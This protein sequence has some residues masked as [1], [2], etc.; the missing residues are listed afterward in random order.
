[1]NKLGVKSVSTTVT[2]MELSSGVRL[3]SK[4]SRLRVPPWQM[5]SSLLDGVPLRVASWWTRPQIDT[6]TEATE[7]DCWDPSLTHPAGAV[8]IATSGEFTGIKFGLTGGSGINFNHAKVGVSTA[9]DSHL[10]IF[11]DMNQQGKLSGPVCASSQN[12]RG[13]LFYVVDDA[14]LHASVAALI[15]GDVGHAKRGP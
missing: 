2:T 5:V 11:G 7:I 4:P 12:G 14:Q 3:I 9:A 6:T 8:E 1:V 10:A 13:G 15:A